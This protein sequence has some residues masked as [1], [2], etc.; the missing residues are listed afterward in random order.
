[1]VGLV[2]GR[3]GDVQW[4][5]AGRA[6]EHAPLAGLVQELGHV[7]ECIDVIVTRPGAG[8]RGTQPLVLFPHG[9]PNFAYVTEY[10]V[11]SAVA[12]RLGY[13]MAASTLLDTVCTVT[14]RRAC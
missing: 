3:K 4:L 2:D 7:G 6:P 1:M 9:G 5:A 13:A 14:D 8:A 10:S 12:A 11:L